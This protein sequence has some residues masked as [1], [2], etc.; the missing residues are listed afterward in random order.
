MH[1]V[2]GEKHIIIWLAVALIGSILFGGYA[3]AK[4][5]SW[6]RSRYEKGEIYWGGWEA[7]GYMVIWFWPISLLCGALY[8]PFHYAVDYVTYLF[9]K[10]EK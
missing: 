4:R 9:E 7:L 3:G 8:I 5:E 1:F 2:F 6:K 10:L